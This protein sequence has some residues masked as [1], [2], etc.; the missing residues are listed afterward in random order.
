MGIQKGLETADVF[1]LMW[2]KAAAESK[3][4]GTE[5]RAYL[6]RRVDDDSL[7]IVPVMVDDTPLPVLVADYRGLSAKGSKAI[8]KVARQI[9]GSPSDAKIIRRLKK[10]LQE[11]TFDSEAKDD[12]LPFKRCPDCGEDDFKRESATDYARDEIYYIISCKKCGWS[13]WGQ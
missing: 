6:R 12:P 13:E 1:V 5:L 2:S 7:R 4:V 10:R 3:W 8:A 11:L 9:C